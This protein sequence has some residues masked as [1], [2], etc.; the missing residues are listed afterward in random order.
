MD[1]NINP[2]YILVDAQELELS[3]KMIKNI[4]KQ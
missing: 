2:D 4:P 1:I 3:L